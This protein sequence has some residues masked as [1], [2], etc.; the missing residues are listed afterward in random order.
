[1]S[2]VDPLS[3]V[4]HQQL[5]YQQ[6]PMAMNVMGMGMNGYP[7]HGYPMY[8]DIYR[9]SANGL[10]DSFGNSAQIM[11]QGLRLSREQEAQVSAQSELTPDEKKQEGLPSRS[12]FFEATKKQSK[13]GMKIDENN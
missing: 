12:D 3:N 9:S 5:I 2:F 10:Q 6:Q 7:I 8:S 4:N 13:E 11:S 1:M